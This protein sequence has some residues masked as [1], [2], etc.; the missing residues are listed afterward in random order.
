[1]THF[2]QMILPIKKY[3][4]KA[5][6]K[7]IQKTLLMLSVKQRL[8]I[9][10]RLRDKSMSAIQGKRPEIMDVNQKAVEKLMLSHDVKHLIHGHTHRPA[11]HNFTINNSDYKRI[12]LGDWYEQ[13]SVLHSTPD[14][15]TL[16]TINT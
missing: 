4:A 14:G 13:G 10:E 12:V 8:K 9:A 15:M 6:N 1:M 3:R 5:R 2:A 16:E 11:V 7:W